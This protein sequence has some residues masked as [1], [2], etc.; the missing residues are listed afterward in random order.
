MGILNT[1][2]KVKGIQIGV[3][4]VCTRLKG[5]QIGA[6][7]VATKNKLPFMVLLLLGY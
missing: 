1:A 6:I 7:N 5:L 4:N 3:V 2:D